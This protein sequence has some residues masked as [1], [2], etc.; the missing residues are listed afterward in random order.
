[1]LD[2]EIKVQKPERVVLVPSSEDGVTNGW[3]LGLLKD[4]SW[5]HEETPW[6]SL[7]EDC[8]LQ[9]ANLP[10]DEGVAAEFIQ[11]FGL[12]DKGHCAPPLEREKALKVWNSLAQERRKRFA[13]PL[14]DFWFRQA[15]MQ[16]CLRYW[17]LLSEG[18]FKEAEEALIPPRFRGEQAFDP[19]DWFGGVVSSHLTEAHVRLSLTKKTRSVMVNSA[20]V[21]DGLLSGLFVQFWQ[22]VSGNPDVAQCEKC[23]R[24]FKRTRPTK[25]Y[26]SLSCQ[27]ADKQRRYRENLARKAMKNKRRK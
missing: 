9:F 22:R 26:C 21:F 3:I 17:N 19:Q 7:P 8:F 16:M 2:V 1:M 5:S 6:V 18:K 25:N 15:W 20:L 27:Q 24:W 14:A 23:S 11:K 4:S 10:S 13:T 12:F